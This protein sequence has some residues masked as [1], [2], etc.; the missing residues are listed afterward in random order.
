MVDRFDLLRGESS[1]DD[2]LLQTDTMRFVAIVGIVFWIIFALIKSIPFHDSQM[3]SSLMPVDPEQA[4]VVENLPKEAALKLEEKA[5]PAERAVVQEKRPQARQRPISRRLKRT[6]LP[7]EPV[8]IR[9]QFQT[10][11]DL[12]ELLANQ[13]VR[14]FGRAKTTGFDLIFAGQ[15]QDGA[16]VFKGVSSLPS[17]LWEIKSGDDH[18][19]F[20]SLMAHSY[21]AIRSFPTRQVLV[22]FD[23]R[24]LEDRLEKT[25]SRLQEQGKNGVLSVTRTG[26][27]VFQEFVPAGEEGQFEERESPER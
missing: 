17:K 9:M 6:P 4:P 7:P 15:P 21:P 16:L 27:M 11:E 24:E 1:E 13:Q 19:Y 5:R 26:E 8:G 12:L 14:L 2:A 18:A 22:S 3:K 23:D 10:I 20:L 25:L